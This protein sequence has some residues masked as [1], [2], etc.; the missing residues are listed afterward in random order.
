VIRFDA[1]HDIYDS[2]AK[3]AIRQIAL[4]IEIEQVE[5]HARHRFDFAHPHA[6]CPHAAPKHP[7]IKSTTSYTKHLKKPKISCNIINIKKYN[8]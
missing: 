8:K 1:V 3:K 7:K 5:P 4:M 6:S 2:T